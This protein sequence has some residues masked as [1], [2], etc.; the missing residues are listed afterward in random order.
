[1]YHCQH[2]Y[3]CV[4]QYS[5]YIVISLQGRGGDVG[6]TW[7]RIVY[8]QINVV[9]Y[10]EIGDLISILLYT[11]YTIYYYMYVID[12][13]TRL[14]RTSHMIR[15][16]CVGL[17]FCAPPPPSICVNICISIGLFRSRVL[18]IPIYNTTP[19]YH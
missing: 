3:L 5:L 16:L 18:I 6:G 14:L 12:N 1:M 15:C 4:I 11:Q 2:I 8:L 10:G 19:S 9:M 7:V 13:I 17:T